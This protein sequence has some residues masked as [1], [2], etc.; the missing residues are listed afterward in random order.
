MRK[1]CYQPAIQAQ[2]VSNCS[3]TINSN[4]LQMK[5]HSKWHNYSVLFQVLSSQSFFKLIKSLKLFEINNCMWARVFYYYGEFYSLSGP[6]SLEVT[7]K[8]LELKVHMVV[9]SANACKKKHKLFHQKFHWQPLNSAS[10]L[11]FSLQC[12]FKVEGIATIV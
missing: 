10:I 5:L 12:Y 8:R 2:P 1:V 3:K 6:F 9:G 7:S 4:Q 11:K